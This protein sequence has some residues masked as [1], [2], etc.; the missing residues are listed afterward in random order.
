MVALGRHENQ[1]HMGVVVYSVNPACKRWQKDQEFKVILGFLEVHSWLSQKEARL[2]KLQANL[3]AMNSPFLL[4]WSV[5]S[6]GILQERK[7]DDVFPS[8]YLTYYM[9][10][11]QS[12]WVFSKGHQF[13]PSHPW[14]IK[15][16]VCETHRGSSHCAF[17]SRRWCEFFLHISPCSLYLHW[18]MWV[19]V[20]WG[21]LALLPRAMLSVG[22]L[23]T[24]HTHPCW[25]IFSSLGAC[26]VS[27]N[28]RDMS[29]S[30]QLRIGCP[31]LFS[32]HTCQ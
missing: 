18:Y 29:P 12:S 14:N 25:P 30:R 6:Q 10:G 15:P 4:E 3:S 32:A 2:P 7:D 1:N 13:C 5:S 27:E 22:S 31:F 9:C 21:V 23:F 8:T 17:A 24:A 11:W 26:Q 20:L 16:C 19:E 28:G